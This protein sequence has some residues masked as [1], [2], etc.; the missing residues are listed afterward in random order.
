MA[1]ETAEGLLG[2]R[3]KNSGQPMLYSL[4]LSTT[5]PKFQHLGR[6]SMGSVFRLK[7]GVL[8][9][10]SLSIVR[11]VKDGRRKIGF[12]RRWRRNRKRKRNLDCLKKFWNNL[13]FQTAGTCSGLLLSMSFCTFYSFTIAREYST[14]YTKRKPSRSFPYGKA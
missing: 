1:T 13:C 14:G 12:L 6:D 9:I 2:K 8:C 5:L 10:H 11:Q 7:R 4:S 3:T